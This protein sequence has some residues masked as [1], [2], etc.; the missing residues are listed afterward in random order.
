MPSGALADTRGSQQG[1]TRIAPV[2]FPE[3]RPAVT[4]YARRVIRRV[5]STWR[6]LAPTERVQVD[7]VVADE[8]DRVPEN[9][10]QPA[11]RR[12]RRRSGESLSGW[13]VHDALSGGESGLVCRPGGSAQ[14][15]EAS[16]R[17]WPMNTW[18][19]PTPVTRAPARPRPCVVR[20]GLRPQR[21]IGRARSGGARSSS[22]PASS[23]ERP[24]P[25]TSRSSLPAGGS[26]S[27]RLPDEIRP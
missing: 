10:A 13:T 26:P 27:S 9:S 16:L 6:S 24:A 20:A 7:A 11:K 25:R 14:P 2:R 23:R 15:G 1:F 4:R 12:R 19:A 5:A 8:L 21:G 3:L 18:P 22:T 17:S